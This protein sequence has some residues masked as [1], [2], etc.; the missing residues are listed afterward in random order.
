MTLHPERQLLAPIFNMC[1]A[2]S[3]IPTIWNTSTTI[4]IY[5]K[6][7]PKE[8][9]NWRQIAISRTIYKL[10]MGMIPNVFTRWLTEYEVLSPSQK[11]FMPHDG[12]F[13]HNYVLQKRILDAK[14]KKDIFCA[15][16]DF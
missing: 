15:F 11:G 7:D 14:N 13:E 4:L 6:G 5:K 12:A 16:L 1:L 8:M 10:Y 9:S 3:K 2:F